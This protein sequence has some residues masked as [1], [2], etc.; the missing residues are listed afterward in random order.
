MNIYPQDLEPDQAENIQHIRALYPADT[1]EKTAMPHPMSGGIWQMLKVAG[2]IACALVA[3]SRYHSLMAA[4][5]CVILVLLVGAIGMSWV[6]V[7]R[8]S[9]KRSKQSTVKLEMP[10]LPHEV[11]QLQQGAKDRLTKAY[12]ELILTAIDTPDVPEAETE[13]SVREAIQALGGSIVH[14]SHHPASEMPED[15]DALRTEAAKLTTEA[16]QEP[17]MVIA[18][19]LRRR[20][21]A[22]VRRA[23]IAGQTALLI[24]RNDALRQEITGQVA[25][26]R[27]SLTAFRISGGQNVPELAHLAANIQTVAMEAG[28]VTQARAE[29]DGLLSEAQEVTL[30]KV[31]RG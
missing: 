25:A 23:E 22:L 16:D 27:T 12:L 5:I 8:G 26:L 15:A 21:D 30:G 29:V 10:L 11:S 7:A 20:A 14:L 9:W 1:L 18:S 24:R 19:S 13:N 4:L 31:T 3:A 2:L 28:A 6:E 17:D